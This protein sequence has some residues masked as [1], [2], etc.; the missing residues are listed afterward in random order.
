MAT[1]VNDW[2]VYAERFEL[3]PC[4]KIILKP[5]SCGANHLP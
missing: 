5:R 4:E 2:R 3:L 1:D